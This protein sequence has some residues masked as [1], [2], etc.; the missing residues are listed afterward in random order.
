MYRNITGGEITLPENSVCCL[1]NINL[2]RFL[3]DGSDSFEDFDWKLYEKVIK[4]ATRFLDN[5]LDITD[6]PFED[7]KENSLLSRRIGLNPWTGLGSFLA[8][9][10]T[11]YGSPESLKV[12]EELGYK[13]RNFTYNASCD[14]SI[15]KGH[16]PKFDERYLRSVFIMSLPS[17]LRKKIG[18][19]GIRN[20]CLLTIPPVGTGSILAGNISGGLEPIF[21]LEYSRKVRQ[22]NDTITSEIVDDY[23]WRKY[24]KLP[25]N[26]NNK[27]AKI[28]PSYFKTSM[29]IDPLVHIEV[30]ALLQ[31]FVDQSISKTANVPNSYSIEDYSKLLMF[32]IDSGV[33]GTTTFR[34]GTREGVLTEIKTNPQPKEESPS[35]G[36]LG[37]LK[38]IPER[39]MELDGKTYKIKDNSSKS[40]YVTINAIEDNGAKKPWEIFL[41]SKA[42]HHELYA[43]IGVLLSLIMQHTDVLPDALEKLKEIRSDSGYLT[44]SFGYV[45]SKT[46]HIALLVEK[47]VEDINGRK[48]KKAAFLCKE[49]GEYSV[50]KTGGCA[51]CQSCG[52]SSCG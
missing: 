37:A 18:D 47:F 15:E 3:K 12:I 34:D 43:G 51:V 24:C 50:I 9:I 27:D 13:A 41:F 6:Y 38:G 21:S 33:K 5:V 28:V 32:A 16:F 48:T 11:E 19:N 35:E 17:E 23:A 8:L 46:E 1:S 7:I 4:I 26:L 22:A 10:K 42:D 14:L 39:P 40:T 36:I 52:A 44:K 20:V 2:T 29:Q 25:V 31:R 45:S 49:C 30:Q